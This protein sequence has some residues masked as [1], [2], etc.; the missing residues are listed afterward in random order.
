MIFDE[1]GRFK[2][3]VAER[4]R[5]VEGGYELENWSIPTYEYGELAGLRGCAD[6]RVANVSIG[7][8]EPI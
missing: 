4:Y 3:F 6:R 5:T 2:D 1:V 7:D 8:Q